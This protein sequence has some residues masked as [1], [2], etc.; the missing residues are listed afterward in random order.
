MDTPTITNIYNIST[1]NNYIS[2]GAAMEG[3]T[4]GG[5]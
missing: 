2:I 4:G 5:G 1:Y 3:G